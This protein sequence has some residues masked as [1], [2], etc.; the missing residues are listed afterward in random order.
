[1]R[2]LVK[3]PSTEST[4]NTQAEDNNNQE[5]IAKLKFEIGQEMG[6]SPKVKNKNN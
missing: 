4:P 1:V 2:K 5:S 3:H 6:I